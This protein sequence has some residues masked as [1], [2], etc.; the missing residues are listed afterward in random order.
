ML[1]EENVM[2]IFD[3]LSE[4]KGLLNAIPHVTENLKHLYKAPTRVSKNG[5]RKLK[6]WANWWT[7]LQHLKMFTKA[8]TSR[9]AED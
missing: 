5:W 1:Q 3:I 9:D 6:H 2:E 8:L 7:R 4:K